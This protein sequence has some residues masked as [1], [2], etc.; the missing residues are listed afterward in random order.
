MK[1]FNIKINKLK[2]SNFLKEITQL[3]KT[4]IVF[5]PNPEM[6]LKSKND[7]VFKK[8]LD[9][10]TYL[11]PDGIWLYI[12]FQILDNKKWKLL[13]LLLL[14]YYFFNL[15]F[16][17]EYLYK[18]Y[19]DRICWSDLTKDIILEAEKKWIK[20]TIIDLYNPNDLNKVK[21]QKLFPKL[22]SKKFPK[23]NFN[24][25]IYNSNKKEQIINK[26]KTSNSKI[27]FSTLGMK[28]QEESIIEIMEK[29]KNI[30]LG[31]GIWSSFDYII[32]FQK[33]APKIFR[34]IWIE[35]LYRLITWPKKI[36]RVKRLYNAIIIFIYQILKNKF[37]K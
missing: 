26:I 13:N 27:L 12:A 8:L 33:R 11:T 25:Y 16:K 20:V 37:N 22:I 10:A 30:K 32:W 1:I 17:R 5:T 34:I 3:D 31:L 2:Y 29:C 18:K 15:F 9:K 4:N 28:K 23:L 19:W 7:L 14:P 24:Y 36:N 21:S 6:L 35:W